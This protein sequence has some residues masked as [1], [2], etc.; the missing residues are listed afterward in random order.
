MPFARPTLT[1]LRERVVTDI[2]SRLP[3]M[4]TSL[5]RRSLAGILANAEA[6]AV[7]S[8][9]GYLDFIARQALPD[10]AE[11]EYL[12]RWAAIWLPEGRK[13]A[14]YANGINA[15]RVTGTTGLPMPAGTLLVRSDGLQYY[16]LND[17]VSTGSDLVTV[18]ASLPGSTY[19]TAAGVQLQLLVPVTGFDSAAIVVAPGITG[20]VDQESIEALR[21]RVIARIQQPPQGGSKSDYETWALEVPGVTRAWVYPLELGP[22]TVTVRI[23]NDDITTGYIPSAAVV[24][25]AQAYIKA[26][27]PVTAEVYVLAPVSQTVPMTI[28]ISPDTTATRAAVVAELQDLFF[29]TAAPG[30]TIPISKIREAVS[31]ASGVNDSRIDSPTTDQTSITGNLLNLG[32]ITWGTL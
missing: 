2:A 13:E 18:A 26:K 30:G 1:E 32:T 10:T 17:L 7:H 19:N 21:A 20:G 12:L 4:S 23:A 16:T 5:L 29:R 3:G 27:A 15:V 14:T 25:A 24:A 22:G 31:V 9:Y 6:G 11:E 28:S 8:L